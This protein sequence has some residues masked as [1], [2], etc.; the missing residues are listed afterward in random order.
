MGALVFSEVHL[1]IEPLVDVADRP[2]LNQVYSV[3][4]V[5]FLVKKDAL[6]FIA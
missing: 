6:I 2:A 3:E 4:L 5:E 1:I